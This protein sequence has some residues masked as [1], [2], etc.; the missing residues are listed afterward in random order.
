MI[1]YVFLALYIL[2]ACVAMVRGH[3]NVNP[4]ILINLFF[5][6]TLL[7]WAIALIWA[8]TDNVKRLA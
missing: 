5:G 2:P 8:M 1:V 6:W 4:I 7:G 3:K